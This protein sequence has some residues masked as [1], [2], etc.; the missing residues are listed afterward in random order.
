MSGNVKRWV[1]WSLAALILTGGL[2]PPARGIAQSPAPPPAAPAQQAAP[3][4]PAPP[5]PPS[6]VQIAN[7]RERQRIMSLLKISAIP[8]GAVSSSPA[9]YNEAEANPYKLLGK[10]DLGTT[11]YPPIDTALVDGDLGFRQH[12]AGHTPEPTWPT[13]LM[14][15]ERY[16][17]AP[18]ATS[19][20]ARN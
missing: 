1:Q 11:V 6:P 5:P 7:Q 13:F 2:L 12:T 3:A 4:Q 9:T 17:A 18:A 16:L 19:S 8:P 15:A 10:K 20:T 14:F